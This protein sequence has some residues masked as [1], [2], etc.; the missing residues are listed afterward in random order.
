MKPSL[1]R[2]KRILVVKLR[3]LG[4]TVLLTAS[5]QAL[6]QA[7]PE[8]QIHVA[9]PTPWAPLL[10]HHPAVS[11]I[12]PVDR[13]LDK[14]ARAKAIARAALKLRHENFDWVI[15][16]HASPSSATL[17]F[18]CGAPVR[19]IHFH[20]AKDK[21]RY[22]TVKIPEKGSIKSMLE[23]DFDTLRALGLLITPGK[24]RPTLVLKPSEMDE[25]FRT[26]SELELKRPVLALGLGS[27]R[28]TKCWPIEHFARLAHLWHQDSGGAVA[29]TGPGESHRGALLIEQ[30]GEFD[31]LAHLSSPSIRLL[32]AVLSQCS[33][34]AGNDSGVRHLAAAV[35]IP[36]VGIF[37]PED[38]KEWQIYSAETD[39]CFFTPQLACRQDHEP[40]S[41]EWCSLQE[42]VTE[43]N[44]CM[45]DIRPELVL[46]ACRRVAR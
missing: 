9:V 43:K 6:K 18:A 27:S 15:N 30:A 39:P 21:D 19:S 33:V 37:G 35:G 12:W 25:G 34:Y 23:K 46:D 45:A 17:S 36:V 32:A 14:L 4:E 8:A 16:L 2:P 5:L 29:I 13:H 40:G 31:Q 3:G 10:I 24:Y 28:P 42:C 38:P 41:P 11:R 22:S 7:H 1:K 20:S 26:L 44:R